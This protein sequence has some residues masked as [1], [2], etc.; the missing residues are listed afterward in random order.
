MIYPGE[1][2]KIYINSQETQEK[3]LVKKKTFDTI[4]GALFR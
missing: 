3:V 4:F 1:N 2:D